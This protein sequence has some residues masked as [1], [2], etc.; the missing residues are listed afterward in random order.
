M[1]AVATV[2]HTQTKKR[3]KVWRCQFC[4][5]GNHGSCPGAVWHHRRVP[6][7]DRKDETRVEPILWRCEC[8]E[9]GHPTFPYCMACKNDD[10]D[11]V[12]PLT[13]TCWDRHACATKLDVRRQ[14]SRTYQMVLRAKVHAAAKR[15]AQRLMTERTVQI[16][17]PDAD[18]TI[19]RLHE[20]LE[21][22]ESAKVARVKEGKPRKSQPPKPKVGS[23]ECCG[24]PTR[25]GRFVPGHDAK[26]A[27]ILRAK[28]KG[29]DQD[30]Y[31]E[32]KR[33]GWLKKLPAALL[34]DEDK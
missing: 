33:R 6:D 12:N 5:T 13:W 1:T 23:C 25:G 8:E 22:I 2:L 34:R 9:P 31:E 11:E 20:F 14:N 28:V 32:L 7:P 16:V 29:G 15:K 18:A 19:E 30:A 27:S 4:A 26:L 3:Q 24:E 21:Q 17:E 10:A